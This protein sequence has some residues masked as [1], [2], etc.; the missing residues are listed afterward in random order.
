MRY[1]RY[2]QGENP[3]PGPVVSVVCD[4]GSHPTKT[5]RLGYFFKQAGAAWDVF[6]PGSVRRDGGAPWALQ[7]LYGDEPLT[8]QQHM[9]LTD[10]SPMPRKRFDLRCNLCGD[11]LPVKIETLTPVLN[12]LSEHA[13][14]WE[15]ELSALRARLAK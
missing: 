10:G 15:L 7:L 3:N 2:P 5:A 9:A 1:V 11:S 14:A 12:R 6:P 8:E 4:A 13:D